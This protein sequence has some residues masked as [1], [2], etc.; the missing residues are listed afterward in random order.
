MVIDC[1]AY[2]S[3]FRRRV[4]LS[5]RS[6]FNILIHAVFLYRTISRRFS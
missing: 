1:C 4:A 3:R 6:V 5:A 2:G